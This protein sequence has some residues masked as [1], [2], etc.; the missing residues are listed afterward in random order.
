MTRK[1]IIVIVSVALVFSLG[2]AGTAQAREWGLS[3]PS[4]RRALAT[5]RSDVTQYVRVVND[6]GVPAA[7]LDVTLAAITQQANSQLRPAW[8]TPRISFI[9]RAK[10]GA[11]RLYLEPEADA[12]GDYHSQDWDMTPAATVTVDGAPADWQVA[13]SHEILE[14]LVD[15]SGKGDEICDPV[16]YDPYEFDGATVS[17]FAL[18][19]W[20]R[21]GSSGPWDYLHATGAAKQD[22]NGGYE[23]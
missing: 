11:Y 23:S 20:F 10:E 21:A 16:A 5:Q 8:G 13:V 18:P 9:F 6:A 7:T 4:M 17:D 12:L 1:L 2:V 14:M 15:P 19:A 22:V 3:F